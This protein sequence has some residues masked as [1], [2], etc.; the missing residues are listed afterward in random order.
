MADEQQQQSDASVREN[1][2]E[3]PTDTEETLEDVETKS[4]LTVENIVSMKVDA[5]KLEL[6]NR[7]LSKSGVKYELQNRLAMSMGLQLPNK[8]STSPVN[9]LQNDFETDYEDFKKYVTREIFALKEGIEEIVF[10]PAN[11]KGK[12]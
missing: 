6:E 11:Q 2:N 10:T 4:D 9:T 5:L 7:T 8:T 12:Y 3:I 1:E